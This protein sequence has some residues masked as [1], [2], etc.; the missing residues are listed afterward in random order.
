[1]LGFFVLAK[2]VIYL[3][4]PQEVDVLVARGETSLNVSGFLLAAAH[5]YCFKGGW[6]FEANVC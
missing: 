3:R 4:L 1:L 6:N 2:V 5:G